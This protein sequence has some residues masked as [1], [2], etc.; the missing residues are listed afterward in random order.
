MSVIVT[1]Q[2]R[3][4]LRDSGWAPTAS[5]VGAEVKGVCP[6]RREMT[7]GFPAY[8]WEGQRVLHGDREL[9]KG[10][11]WGQVRET[12]EFGLNVVSLPHAHGTVKKAVGVLDC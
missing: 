2:E 10:S 11:R 3:S 5:A 7:S 1:D 6:E 8:A 4:V 9:Q 12:T